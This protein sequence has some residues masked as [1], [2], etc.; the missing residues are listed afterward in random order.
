MVIGSVGK[1]TFTFS[2]IMHRWMRKE[3][4]EVEIIHQHCK[5]EFRKL[6]VERKKFLSSSPPAHNVILSYFHL[7]CSPP[8]LHRL[9]LYII[10]IVVVLDAGICLE[11]STQFFSLLRLSRVNSHDLIHTFFTRQA[12]FRDSGC[13]TLTD[14][15]FGAVS[16][17]A[18]NSILSSHIRN[19]VT[20]SFFAKDALSDH[21]PLK[22][23]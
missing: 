16:H 7:F 20:G 15:H 19:V 3:S 10:I 1:F 23:T 14:T 5:C 8:C 21:W 4:E 18:F 12:F 22:I 17:E 9:G 6:L 11:I 13:A 2:C